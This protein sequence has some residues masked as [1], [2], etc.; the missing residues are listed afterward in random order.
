MSEKKGIISAGNWI[1]DHVK[2]IDRFP[3]ENMLVNIS[4]VYKSVGGGPN[5]VL[6][7]L[8]CLNVGIPLYA[9]GIIGADEDGNYIME[10]LKR[11]NINQ[12]HIQVSNTHPTSFTDAMTVESTGNRTF[13]HNRGANAF[14][15]VGHLNKI[16]V[17][18]KIFHLAYLLL[19]DSLDEA[20]EEHG[21]KAAILLKELKQKGYK[22]SI[23]VVSEESEKMRRIV[24]PC[25]PYVDYL[26]INEI[27]AG[28]MSG[29]DVRENDILNMQPVK[30][31]AKQLINKGV[32][33]LVII[34]CPEGAYLV[35]K[36]GKE[37]WVPSWKISNDEIKGATGAGDAFC[38]GCLYGIHE[39]WPYGK[40][41]QFAHAMAR[42]NLLDPTSVGGAVP[43]DVM[44]GFMTSAVANEIQLAI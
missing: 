1:V 2:I 41:L 20:D 34:H 44:E 43:L 38:A 19:L 3:L 18:A 33:E 12:K 28:F 25:L 16:D 32:Q 4:N 9:A 7:D 42:F 23:D 22:T 10:Q 6:T 39:E 24:T 17:G 40:T 35:D 14:L 31:T 15:S 5:N 36:A 27:E 37:L 30:K 13:F 29:M 8:A 21:V 11:Y 26:I